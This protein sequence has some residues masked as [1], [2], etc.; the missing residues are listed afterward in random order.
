[1]VF[2]D[3]YQINPHALLF[4]W[5]NFLSTISLFFP[6]PAPLDV[7]QGSNCRRRTICMGRKKGMKR[8]FI[9]NVIGGRSIWLCFSLSQKQWKIHKKRKLEKKRAEKGMKGEKVLKVKV[10]GG[11]MGAGGLWGWCRRCCWSKEKQN[12]RKKIHW[13]KS[14]DELFSWGKLWT[15]AEEGYTMVQ[16]GNFL[17][18]M[19]DFIS[20]IRWILISLP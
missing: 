7:C 13:S 2:P 20:W 17:L 14:V 6:T 16:R 3:S 4:W 5:E 15:F 10:Y 18:F 11:W 19:K 8:N 12:E 9:S 1:M